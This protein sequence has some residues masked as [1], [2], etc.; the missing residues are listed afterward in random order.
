MKNTEQIIVSLTTWS[1]RICNI[2]AVLDSIF[3]QTVPPD[4]VVLNLAFD[5]IVPPDVDSYIRSHNI[6]VNR[7]EDTRTYKKLF[8]TLERYPDACVINIDDDFLYP[9][10][11]IEDF[12]KAHKRHP[13][14]PISGNKERYF[15]V[16]CHCGCASLTKKCHFGK[17]F[18]LLD[19]DVMSHCASDDMVYTYLINKNGNRYVHTEGDY[20]VN[21][22]A[23]NPSSP[24]SDSPFA[25]DAAEV[26]WR[27][28]NERFGKIEGINGFLIILRRVSEW[29]RLGIRHLLEKL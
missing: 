24:Y 22:P 1:A 14:R 26:T 27:Y 13:N 5:E 23:Y 29:L 15:Y 12:V 20:Y 17:C 7:V 3:S 2:P 28:L 8:P 4:L 19:K 10:G 9:S 21:L 16:D 6:I 11:M 25:N 18:D